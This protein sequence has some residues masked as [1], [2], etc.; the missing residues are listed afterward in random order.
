MSN[1][2]PQLESDL[3][4]TNIVTRGKIRSQQDQVFKTLSS[5]PVPSTSALSWDGKKCETMVREDYGVSS[6]R[7]STIKTEHIVVTDMLNNS[8]IAEFCPDNGTGKSIASGVCTKVKEKG[9]DLNR[10]HFICGDSTNSNT[11]YKDGSFSWFEEYSLKAFHW[12]ICLSHLIELPLRKAVQV[13]VG[14]SSG[15]GSFKSAMGIELQSLNC[16]PEPINFEPIPCPE[17]VTLSEEELKTKN[18]SQDQCIFY[19]LCLSVI[20]GVVPPSLIGRKL[21]LCNFARWLT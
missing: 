10:V 9:I 6:S 12:V 8:F 1:T 11:G 21:G 17:F 15:P 16:V 3:N 2:F 4:G 5:K 20:T 18:W 7:N 14:E 13:T 19:R